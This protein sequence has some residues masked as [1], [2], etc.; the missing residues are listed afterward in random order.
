MQDFKVEQ[1]EDTTFDLVIENKQFVTVDSFETAIYYQMFTNKRASRFQ[2]STP[3]ERGGWLGDL[4]TKPGYEAGSYLYTKA[5]SRNT[6]TDKNE[7]AEYTK[8]CL[9][10]FRKYGAKRI[11]AEIIGDNIAGT[12]ELSNDTTLKYNSLWRAI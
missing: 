8:L 5:Q 3:R 4:I 6:Q 12:I 2:V 7:I 10:Y 1:L 11:T 9:K